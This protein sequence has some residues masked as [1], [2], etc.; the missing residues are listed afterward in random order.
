[1]FGLGVI[2]VVIL[3]EGIAA[4]HLGILTSQDGR[5]IHIIRCHLAVAEQIVAY[6]S[7]EVGFRPV[8]I[9]FDGQSECANRLRKF[10]DSAQSASFC[11]DFRVCVHLSTVISHF[12]R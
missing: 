4:P 6:A 5:R 3:L 12:I 1:M 10:T 8:N 2:G 11:I 9:V 7:S